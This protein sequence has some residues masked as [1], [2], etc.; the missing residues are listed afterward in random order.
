MVSPKKRMKDAVPLDHE[1][2][3]LTFGPTAFGG[4]EGNAPR[5]LTDC[6]ATVHFGPPLAVGEHWRSDLG[7]FTIAKLEN[8]RLAIVASALPQIEASSDKISEFGQT[9]ED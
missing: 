1:F 2:V 8:T 6:G 3:C 7:T 5:E 9:L 4:R